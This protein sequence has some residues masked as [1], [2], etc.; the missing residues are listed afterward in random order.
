MSAT[1]GHGKRTW[2][3]SGHK[4]AHID[5]VRNDINVTPLVDVMLVLLIIF[6][7]MVL[8]TGRGQ[9][10]NLPKEHNYSQEEDKLQPV[11]SIDNKG[12]VSFE[13]TEI[14][15]SDAEATWKEMEGRLG[16]RRADLGL[17]ER[18]LTLV[19]DRDDGLELVLFLRVVVLL[20]QVH[21]LT[22]AG[23]QH[24]QHED[25]EQHQHD[26]DERRHVDVVADRVD[27]ALLV[28][29]QSPGALAMSLRGGH[30]SLSPTLAEHVVDELARDVVH[31]DHE[32]LDARGE[33]V[34]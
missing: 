22:T 26:V 1:K 24:H 6:M 16:V 33:E 32:H 31:V 21:V 5:G 12:Q 11:V 8:L 2:R 14:G 13:K 7:L 3:L 9:D 10:V 34:E 25:D 4:K 30:G 18:D 15:P 17:L 19:V 20:G 23:Q 27:V 28:A 29:R